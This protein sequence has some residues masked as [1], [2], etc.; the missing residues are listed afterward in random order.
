MKDQARKNAN[1]IGQVTYY[2]GNY[3]SILQCYATQ[4]LFQ[5]YGFETNLIVLQD[6]IAIRA[7]KA[8]LRRAKLVVKMLRFPQYA[9]EILRLYKSAQTASTGKT[10]MKQSV[11]QMEHFTHK[12][13]KKH[14]LTG[15]QLKKAARSSE[16]AAFLSG[17]DQIW[18]ASWPLPDE[19]FYLRF[20]PAHKRIAFAPS[21]GTDKLSAYNKEILR[22]ISAYELL[23]V[24]EASGLK[25]IRQATHKDCMVLNDP[26][27]QLSKDSWD[28]LASNS[29]VDVE[30]AYI[31]LFFIDQPAAFVKDILKKVQSK[32]NLKVVN[33][34][35]MR[36]FPC[37]NISGGPEDFLKIL[38]HA[39]LVITDSFHAMSFSILFQSDFYI[40]KRNYQHNSDQSVRITDLL[41]ECA[42]S[43]RFLTDGDIDD[44]DTFGVDFSQSEA[45]V[46]SISDK[47]E[48][49]MEKLNLL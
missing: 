26:V 5:K 21:L 11:S 29:A 2:T 8:L 27:L 24:R 18:S 22:Y 30:E 34:G 31:C 7:I 1:K 40:V 16:Y 36:D 3:G 39:K 47:T 41:T 32:C 9:G 19:T 38:K 25:I 14:V 10:L 17:S 12:H 37:E 49:F 33:F 6:P 42:L 48:Q 23:S 43:H 45:F 15:R 35:Y 44:S 46:K 13:I 28:A 4:R 20:A